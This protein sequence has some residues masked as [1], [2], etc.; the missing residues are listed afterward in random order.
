MV[1][2]LYTI[3]SNVTLFAQWTATVSTTPV[4][5]ITTQPP[6]RTV[7]AGSIS[8]NLSV[9]ASVTQGAILS[10]QWFSNTTNSNVGGT[11]ISGATSANFNIPTTLTAGT[12]H[13]FVEVRATGGA[14]SVRSSVATVTVNAPLF[15]WTNRDRG[16]GATLPTDA[17]DGDFFRLQ[18]NGTEIVLVFV[19]PG[20]FMYGFCPHDWMGVSRT[21]TQGFWIGRFP[22]TQ[23][24]YQ[25][26]MS[27]HPTLSA[28][29]SRFSG[30]PSNPVEQVGWHC[31]TSS[32]GF[33][34]R[35]GGR[36]PTSSEWEFAAR[37]GNRRGGNNGGTDFI[38]AGSNDVNAVSWYWGHPNRPGGT[39][40]T[41]PVGGLA[42]N[43]LGINDMS[44]NVWEWTSTTAGGS[45]H[46]LRG[47]NWDSGAVGT[48]VASR[49][50]DGNNACSGGGT[51]GFRVVFDAN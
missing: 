23:A 37:G 42:A 14:T 51:C 40:N 47:G 5:T 45:S 44:G 13:Y 2:S 16:S 33:L 32:N 35:V 21:I 26:V 8:E 15:T 6:S 19:T 17:I 30:R 3:N 29:P 43:E 27:G 24:Q 38:W 4:I 25:A 49:G 7:T 20:T 28:T 22:V 10:Y 48:R 9:S 18:T 34:E 12:Y 46:V 50:T 31:I 39:N 11:A 36:L 41:Q 1:N